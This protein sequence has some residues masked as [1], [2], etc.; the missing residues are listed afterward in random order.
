MRARLLLLS[1]L[2]LI[3]SACGGTGPEA[4]SHNPSDPGSEV[5]RPEERGPEIAVRDLPEEARQVLRLIKE[6]GPFPYPR[7]GAVFANRE[8]LLPA[9]SRGYYREYTV[10]TPG[11]RSRGARR[12]IASAKG[13]YYYT[14]DHY[15]SFKRIRE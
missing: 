10:E 8:R 14:D 11:M 13:D 4:S 1:F 5:I 12:I 9:R 6:G 15:R 2:V 7:D 3:I